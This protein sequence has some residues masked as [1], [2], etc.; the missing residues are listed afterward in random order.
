MVGEGVLMTCL[1]DDRI[2][3]IVV[4]NR[5]PCGYVHPKLTEI[6]HADFLDFNP[7]KSK[8]TG[9]D[10]CFFCLGVTSIGKNEDDYTRLTH[11]LTLHIAGILCEA[12]PGMKFMYISGAGTDSTEKGRIM[13][14]RVK[15]KTENDLKQLPFKKVYAFRPGYIQPLP[16]ARYTHAFYPWVSW[17][18]PMLKGFFGRYVST[19]GDIGKAMVNLLDMEDE[20]TVLEAG[21]INRIAST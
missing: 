3:R 18:Y 11:T 12:N 16:G 4:V 10:A 9:L 14:A 13:W 20:K 7:I 15:G 2:N 17:M 21:D 8:L 6:I 19:L 5:R 1:S